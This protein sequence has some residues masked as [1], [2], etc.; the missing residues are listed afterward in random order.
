M[1]H[2][3]QVKILKKKPHTTYSSKNVN[4]PLTEQQNF[5]AKNQPRDH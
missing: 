1:W 2:E 4:F 5:T 3:I